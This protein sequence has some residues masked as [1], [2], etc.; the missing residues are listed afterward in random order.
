MAEYKS[1]LLEGLA[2]MF[3]AASI[4][5]YTAGQS[6]APS[7]RGIW[8]GG[9]PATV[10]EGLALT[11]YLD[12]PGVLASN[13]T[14]V[15]VRTRG[16]K[17]YLTSTDI[18]DQIRNLLHRRTHV[19]IGGHRIDLIEQTSFAYLGADANGRHEFTQNFSLRGIRGQRL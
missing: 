15:Q 14:M 10:G 7:E 9:I 5:T 16:S 12:V 19:N 13:T 11:Q 4:G 3:D 1:Q 6:P 8:F 2:V 18:T 17:N